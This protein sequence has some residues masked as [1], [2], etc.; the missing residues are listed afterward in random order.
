[1]KILDRYILKSFIWP[2]FAAFIIVLLVFVLQMLWL[3]AD[4][5]IGKGIGFLS[6]VELMMYLSA[7]MVPMALP[8]SI[9]LSSIMTFGNLSE[10][11]ELTAFKAAGIPLFRIMLSLIILMMF[12]SY[13]AFA[14]SNKVIPYAN[15]KYENL[16]R[17][18]MNKKPAL[19]LEPGVFTSLTDYSIRVGEKFPA[20]DEKRDSIRN[21]LIY[22]L[23]KHLG[24]T[25]IIVAESGSITT[26][27]DKRYMILTLYDG[28]MYDEDI[29]ASSSQYLTRVRQ[30][31]NKSTFQKQVFPIDISSFT[32][33]DLKESNDPRFTMLDISQL[34]VA[35][36]SIR[37]KY[38][39]QI[40]D[41]SRDMG[42]Y[43]L[44]SELPSDSLLAVYRDTASVEV[45]TLRSIVSYLGD[46][47][48]GSTY[49]KSRIYNLSSEKIR[50]GQEY[51]T[52]N[53]KRLRNSSENANNYGLEIHRKYALAF[54]VIVL[55]FVGA[56][57]GALIRK[58][59][60]GLPVVVAIGIFVIYNIIFMS[61]E[62]MGKEGTLDVVTA[63]W[64]PTWI[65]LPFGIW[66][67]Y[68]AT[69]DK[70]VIN[71]DPLLNLFDKLWAKVPE[72]HRKKLR[73]KKKKNDGQSQQKTQ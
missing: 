18:M 9:L 31:I 36:D 67:T 47:S 26:S 39:E 70:V 5:I 3:Y 7:A 15:F 55:F 6:I 33:A 65:L 52:D 29:V 58:G 10:N 37:E 40:V 60:I 12:V 50:R 54:L 73:F 71:I 66:L 61:A 30:A 1:M 20:E 35:L 24:T 22:D 19:N 34:T 41:F 44:I 59:G 69:K 16:L 25:T 49:T 72:R 43:N 57:L 64:L 51:L 56:P 48:K 32:M 53:V 63:R 14:F 13:G 38:R 62:R 68:R 28:H 45:D 2:F 17:N 8:V 27:P 42:F 23:S 46:D 4:D 21:V 11:S